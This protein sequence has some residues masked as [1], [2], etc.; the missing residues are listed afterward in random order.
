MPLGTRP[1]LHVLVG[2]VRPD[3]HFHGGAQA[4]EEGGVVHGDADEQRD[5]GHVH[6]PAH[7]HGP[8]HVGGSGAEGHGEFAGRRDDNVAHADHDPRLVVWDTHTMRYIT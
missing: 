3:Q 2:D 8:V 6:V 1:Y 5:V 4:E 7:M